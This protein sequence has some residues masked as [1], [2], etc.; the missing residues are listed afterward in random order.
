[1]N[2]QWKSAFDSIHADEEL[3]NRTLSAISEQIQRR[4]PKRRHRLYPALAALCL[5]LVLSGF[6]YWL[7]FVPTA[8][9]S[10]DVNP[11]LELSI[12]RFDRIL[13][14]TGY[15]DDGWEIANSLNLQNMDYR[16]AL[17]ELLNSQQIEAYLNEDAVLSMTVAG[18][19]TAQCGQILHEVESCTSQTQNV[20]CHSGSTEQLEQ[21][22]EAGM[23]FGKYQA[24]LILQELDPTVTTEQVQGLTM[25]QIWQR[26][27]ELDGTADTNSD[28]TATDDST[29]PSTGHSD[30]EHEHEGQKHRYGHE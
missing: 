13:A 12:N 23:S 8:F 2:E 7:Y 6:G 1:M 11:S 9:I 19:D 30:E 22:H 20:H 10:V 16:Q 24:F 14:V 21:A 28:T 4:Q 3:K 17:Q 5:V 15:N 18:E 25:R 27:D 29:V 26:I